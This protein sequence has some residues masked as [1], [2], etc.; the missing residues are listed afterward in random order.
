MKNY[1]RKIFSL[2]FFLG[3][4]VTHGFCQAVII[5]PS[6]I[7]ISCTTDYSNTQ[8]TGVPEAF[9]MGGAVDVE[10]NDII[11]N[12]DANGEGFVR[13]RWNVVGSA[14]IFCDHTILMQCIDVDFVCVDNIAA[15]L[16]TSD[17]GVANVKM[18]AE[19]LVEGD[20]GDNTIVAS[21]E[22]ISYGDYIVYDCCDIGSHTYYVK[23][24]NVDENGV[25]VDEICT[26]SITIE[27]KLPPVILSSTPIYLSMFN[28]G[29][30][31]LHV[32][33][34]SDFIYDN[35]QDVSATFSQS[36][37]TQ[38]GEYMVDVT[39]SDESSNTST[40]TLTVIVSSNAAIACNNNVN[41]SLDNEGKVLLTPDMILEG[42]VPANG[43]YTIS[44]DGVQFSEAIHLDCSDQNEEIEISVR[45]ETSLVECWSAI[46]IEDK[47]SPL[48]T[49]PN[50]VY[51]TL[52]VPT[53]ALL[54]TEMLDP[55]T[56]DNC[57]IVS[58]TLS[59]GLFA[60][61]GSYNVT[62]TVADGEGNSTV[63]VFEVIVTDGASWLSCNN[64]LELELDDDGTLVVD[65]FTIADEAVY[66][67]EDF[68][69]GISYNFDNIPQ[70]GFSD[71]L[72]LDC[73]DVG[74]N[75]RLV[76]RDQDTGD[77]C[78]G[79]V[80]VVDKKAPTAYAH[81]VISVT[82]DG[83]NPYVLNPAILDAGSFD[84]CGGE[85]TFIASPSTFTTP[86][87][88]QVKLRVFDESGNSDVAISTVNVLQGS[89]SSI[90][91][92]GISTAIANP[93]GAT[94]LWA[95]DFVLND[96]DFDSFS[97]STNLNGPY[98]ES[99]DFDCSD[100]NLNAPIDLYVVA[101]S[102]GI[103]ST[104]V[105]S[106]TLVDNSAPVAVSDLNIILELQ[107][108]QAILSPEVV[109]D[110][111]YDLCGNI[112]L[113][114][115]QTIFTSSDI[116]ENQ[117]TLTVT[118]ASGNTNQAV[119]IVTVVNN[120]DDCDDCTINDVIFPAD[121]NVTDTDGVIE[122]LS[123]DNLQSLYNYTYDQ[124][125]PYTIAQCDDIAYAYDD[126][127]VITSIGF[128]VLRSFTAVDWGTGDVKTHVQLIQL[129]TEMN[130]SLSCETQLTIAL[131]SGNI[132]V[133]P[134]DVLEGGPYNLDVIT[135]TITDENGV[136]VPDN[137][138]SF[139]YAGQLLTYQ[140]TDTQT[141]TSC[142]GNINV[143]DE[144]TGCALDFDNEVSLPLAEISIVDSE[145]NDSEYTPDLLVENFGFSE[146]EVNVLVDSDC[147]VTSMIYIDIFV[148][149]TGN[150]Y[151]I[152]RTFTLLDW[153]TYDQGSTD[154][155]YTIV[156]IINVNTDAGNLICDILPN[157]APVG[158]CESGHTLSDD[159][160]WPSDI[161]ITDYRIK[162]EE[163]I[164]FSGVPEIDSEPI[165]QNTP[166][167][168][169]SAYVDIVVSLTSTTLTIDRVWTATNTIYNIDWNY[170]QTIVIDFSDFANLVTVSTLGGR[171]MPGVVVN[172]TME[173]DMNGKVQVEDAIQ[174]VFY[175]EPINN[176]GINVLDFI[177]IQRHI[178]AQ[179]SLSSLSL[180]A[181]DVN[182]DGAVK[183]S[184]LVELKKSF[185]D[186]SPD[187][188]WRFLDVAVDNA[189]LV[190]PKANYLAIKA[191]DVDDSAFLAGDDMLGASTDFRISDKLLNSGESYQIPVFLESG[192]SL[193]GAQIS[194]GVDLDMLT[195]DNVESE[196]DFLDVDYFINEDGKMTLVCYNALDVVDPASAS[197]G[198]VVYI[199]A[200]AKVN[201]IL[202][203][204]IVGSD[205]PSY[206]VDE[207]LNLIRLGTDIEDMIGTGTNSPEL[208]HISAYP[209]PASDY[210]TIDL[211]DQDYG[212]YTISIFNL[213][214][215][216]MITQRN[217]STI[218]L[219]NLS[220]G[221]Y[222]YRVDIG[223]YHT[224][225]KFIV[226]R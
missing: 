123:I 15:S 77:I 99:I 27:D 44:R 174:S 222:Y 225:A 118:D 137:D 158:D 95:V 208:D 111:S 42:F 219:Q 171:A 194:L 63:Q 40:A 18:F 81:S 105:V 168:Y 2:C 119:A 175:D 181:A 206:V 43:H 179:E 37:F 49:V 131:T 121:I 199:E 8:I 145:F 64:G 83:D 116:G 184:D 107:N 110:G 149:A 17:D 69:I 135:L 51:L 66:L 22:G 210:L 200:T 59:N 114:L 21:R 170:T 103:P 166:D 183:A 191:G 185:L 159:V 56:S 50:P 26:G 94:T 79:E 155:I 144:S 106:L 91:C 100:Y 68:E 201:G 173:T 195:I 153:V 117:V 72:T 7:S 148:G 98:T 25:I 128:N 162:P 75:T 167:D 101:S 34:L 156:Q 217:Q 209:N 215:Q 87:S 109:D 52:N 11:V 172:G 180:L 45:E 5:C 58:Q 133:F 160:E 70:G 223:Q 178:L 176:N 177:L 48:L 124:V 54:T 90:E 212:D 39:A 197:D 10:Y 23:Y 186:V 182:S 73:W 202:H 130:G 220:A 82:L 13:R 97:M 138:I 157:S 205:N 154:G 62:Y 125:Y 134:A 4:G 57:N 102:A 9:D 143:V 55:Y 108:C 1:L 127:V 3:L 89:G 216:R 151:Q 150:T 86:G 129:F 161:M 126:V 207:G 132:T 142:F 136:V 88:Y 71:N 115:S 211:R 6:D 46:L 163:L 204:A 78:G 140:V 14:H 190:D 30:V 19:S 187:V 213:Q 67:N 189:L 113:S 16:G 28:Q 224:V 29:S 196:L 164:E 218:D 104:C 214:G 60:A 93:W 24:N 76:V 193:F 38:N 12:L 122:Y 221:Q 165:F 139:N 92:V 31:E 32:D 20:L 85:V 169:E 53:E 192:H 226:I 61:A 47:L 198:A 96:E 74:R 188:D 112:T 35:C 65:Y 203:E 141:G 33:M 152:E 146:A 80:T 147:A 41:I 36:V 84:N 120:N